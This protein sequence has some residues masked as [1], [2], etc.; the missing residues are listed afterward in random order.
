MSNEELVAELKDLYIKVENAQ[1]MVK[2][3]KSYYSVNKLEGIKQ[4]I[5]YIL[6]KIAKDTKIEN[7]TEQSI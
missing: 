4:K 7:N 3:G 2:D 5:M 6:S 1:N